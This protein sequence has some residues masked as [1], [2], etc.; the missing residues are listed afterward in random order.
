MEWKIYEKWLDIT[1]YRQMTNLIYKLSSNEEK[2]KIY[3]QLKE[4]DMFLEKPKVDMETAYGLHYPG[5]VLE[6]IGEHLTLT[7]QTYRALGLALARMMPLQETCMFNGTQKDLFWKK[8]KQI[9]GEKDLFLISINY[10]CEE[11]EKNRWKQ[12]MHAYP[13]ERAEE[14][15]FAMSILPDDETLWEGI[16]QKLADSFSKNR[17]ISV[18]TEWNL[19]V[20]MVGKVMTKLKGYRKKD[21]DI[22][23]LLVKL[24]GTN[25]KNA[26][27]VLEKRMRMFGYSDKETAFLNFVLMY[28]VERPD[29]I[30]LSGL[31]AEKIG[32]NVL[33]AFLPGKE[34]YP[35]EAY[36]LC[37]R[38]LRTYGKL[39][40]RIDGKERLEKCMN[41]T[42]RVE[43][44]KTFLTLFPFRSNE[45]EEWHYI[46]LTEEKWDPLVKELSSEEFEACVTDTLKGKTY[47]T[48]SLLKYL[49]RYENLTGKRYQDVFWKKSEPELYAVFNRLILHGI[50]DGKKYLEEFVKD[51]KNEDPD[52]EKKWEFMAGYL[53]SEIKG[54]CKPRVFEE[55]KVLYNVKAVYIDLYDR[56][57]YSK[58]DDRLRVIRE[59]IKR[60]CLTDALEEN[61]IECLA[62]ALSKKSLSRWMQEDFK[63][64]LDL[65]HET[66]IWIL[67]FLMDFTEL[68]K[69]LT[70]DNQVYF[71]LHNQNLLNGCS[72]LPAL[73]DKLLSQ[74]P[75][76]KNLKTEL[77]ISDAFV[78]ENKSNIQKFIYEG[79]AEIMT[80]FL[81]RQ[82]KKKEEIRRIVNAE[83]LGKFM[84]LKYHEGDLGR[85]IA[86]PIKKDTEE[87][88]KEKLL[89]VDCGWEI[90]EEDSLLPVMQIGEVPLRSCISYRNG[91]NC[92]CL[93]SCFDANKKIIFIKHNGKIVFRAIL[94][95]TK[96]SFVAADERK[97]IEFVDVTA[98]SEP[99]ENKAEELVLFL[100]RYY[101]SG[102]SEQEIRKAVNLTAML[103]KEKAEK[104]GARLVLSSSYK[105]VL[106]NKNYVL[107]NFYMYISASKNGSQYLDSLG[108]AAGVSASGR[109]TCNTFLLEAE[110]RREESL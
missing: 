57:A 109:Y 9:L 62:E 60:D 80:S 79:G 44:V 1:L 32:L 28:F 38:I 18:F 8:M 47:S 73:M 107:T 100:E 12:A 22:L 66:A 78:A 72:G 4:N 67:I 85:E 41:E 87:I 51:Y 26:D 39:S 101:Q 40:V 106:E 46:D 82:P 16:K 90:W 54:L 33:E 20:W 93:L 49:E 103:V 6:R 98:K 76:W 86:F 88:W 110:E 23:K 3:M 15:L 71:L 91:P 58:S 2:Y 65:R 42:F 99:H 31:T 68:L 70:K 105:N 48:K 69:D 52:L 77:N 95:L 61:Q 29:R 45:P 102:L 30:S 92:D 50:L 25:A 64:I 14:M 74:D 5:E 10:I 37:S 89:R 84:E 97:T 55:L 53:K 35:E 83:L 24:T 13:F 81:N 96:G 94:R 43:N 21:L 63:N 108:G 17:K 34:T 27:A 75:S 7:K 59:L 36:V 11:K 19:F 104:L 56:L